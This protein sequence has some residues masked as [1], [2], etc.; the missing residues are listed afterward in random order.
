LVSLIANITLN[1]ALI[2]AFGY[3]GASWA[4]NLTEVVLLATG[5]AMVAR[6]IGPVPM[7]RLS[8]RIL[9]AGLVMAVPLWFMRGIT[10]WPVL[11]AILVAMAV[12]A[13]ALVLLRA[14]DRDELALLRRALPAARS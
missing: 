3:L 11:I 12:Y 6:T 4:T 10:G 5:W 14:F 7:H 2:P 1:F 13:A 8:W 9:L